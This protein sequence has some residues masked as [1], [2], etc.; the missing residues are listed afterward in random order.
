[1]LEV[2]SLNK[3]FGGLQATHDVDYEMMT[4]ELSAIIGPNGAGK[5]TFFN[6]LTGYHTADSGKIFF[7]GINIT[8]WPPHKITRLGI[9]RAFQVSNI[10]PRLTTY[11]NVRQAILAQQKKTINLFTPA[12]RLARRETTE[13]LEITGLSEQSDMVAG[14]LSQGDKKRLELAIALGSRPELLFLD[15][16][17]AGMSGEETHDTM[18][19]VKR[20]NREI[21]LTI[22]FTEHDMSVVFGYAR[23]LTVLHQGAVIAEGTPEEVRDNEEAQRVYLGEEA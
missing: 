14:N 2:E 15:E 6:L 10:Y 7:K 19:L 9:A 20:L 22:L 18:E 21:G 12:S 4:G 13:L 16:P 1:M 11:E 5:S 17:T 23:R 8:H 3:A